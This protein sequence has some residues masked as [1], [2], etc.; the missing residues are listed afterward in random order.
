MAMAVLLAL[1]LQVH[2]SQLP[3]GGTPAPD[4]YVC[5]IERRLPSGRLNVL[6]SG[7]ADRSEIHYRMRW[8]SARRGSGPGLNLHWRGL[9]EPDDDAEA[10]VLFIIRRRIGYAQ[11]DLSGGSSARLSGL[12]GG[13]DSVQGG[14]WAYSSRFQWAALDQ[15]VREQDRVVA[16]LIPLHGPTAATGRIDVAM[17]EAPAAAFL[18]ARAA[19]ERAARERRCGRGGRLAI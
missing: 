18:A 19:I 1:A 11:I 13:G 3:P 4:T 2:V 7:P 17:I 16:A 14:G 9:A 6:V 15:L 12:P 8:S 10:E 5:E